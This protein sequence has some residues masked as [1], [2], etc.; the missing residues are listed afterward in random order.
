MTKRQKKLWPK[1]EAQIEKAML[2]MDSCIFDDQGETSIKAYKQMIGAMKAMIDA[3][4]Q[5]MRIRQKYIG[6]R[7]DEA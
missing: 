2:K 7:K 5:I 3:H 4:S 1:I 6:K